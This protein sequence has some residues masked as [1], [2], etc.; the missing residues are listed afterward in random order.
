[1]ADLTALNSSIT[2]LVAAANALIAAETAAITAATAAGMMP[3]LLP[4]S[5]ISMR[6]APID[7][8]YSGAARL[9]RDCHAGRCDEHAG[10]V[11]G[12]GVA[13]R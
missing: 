3:A 8:G 11:N 12:F 1:M 4:L 10:A 6:I 5:A 7:A 13:P 2:N 9:D